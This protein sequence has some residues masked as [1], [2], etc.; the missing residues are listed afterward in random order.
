MTAQAAGLAYEVHGGHP[1]QGRPP[2]VL[3]HGAGGSRLFWPPQ[4]R[5]LPGTT[6]YAVDLP[7]HGRSPGAGRD[8]IE[9]YAEDLLRWMAALG[10]PRCVIAGHSMGSAVALMTALVRPSAAAGLVLVGGGG[11]LRVHPGILEAVVEPGEFAQAVD[12]IVKAA[13]GPQARA[14]LIEIS[15]RRMLE[16]QQGVLAGDLHACD[17]FDVLDRLGEISVPTL[18]VCGAHDRL[19]PE[20]YS[21]RLVEAIA[22]AELQIIPDAGHMVMLERPDAVAAAIARFIVGRFPS[23]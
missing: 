6:V 2:L 5:R 16:T 10:L 14:W 13:Y 7:G 8:R 21:R 17:A 4:I 22:G 12:L 3:V 19:T 23:G 11:R 9:A 1:D 15:R 18:V 20:K